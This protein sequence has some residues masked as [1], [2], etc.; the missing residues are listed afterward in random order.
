MKIVIAGAG[1]VGYQIASQLILEKRSVVLIE[2]NELIA[3]EMSNRLDCM[4]ICGSIEDPFVLK[5]AKIE[6]ASYFL[7]LTGSDEINIVSCSIADKFS[8]NIYKVARIR[9]PSYLYLNEKEKSLFNIDYIVNPQSE[10]VDMIL[11]TIEYG[12]VSD[13]FSLGE[14]NLDISSLYID[15]D[16]AAKY[17]NII[18][19]NKAINIPFLVVLLITSKN[20]IL[21]PN[22]QSKIKAGD[23][24][25]VCAN[26][27]DVYKVFEFFNKKTEKIDSI[28]IVGGDVI[29]Q[30]ILDRLDFRKINENIEDLKNKEIEK[31]SFFSNIFSIFKRKDRRIKSFFKKR[32]KIIE[33]D[34]AV[35]KFLSENY[36]DV[37][38]INDSITRDGVFEDNDL[39]KADLI[40]VATKNQE[41]NIVSSLYAKK[42]GIEKAVAIVENKSYEK[43]A[44]ELGI[45]APISFRNS[46][47]SSVLKLIK[48]QNVVNIQSIADGQV[49]IIKVI[50]NFDS[51][52]INR[53][54]KNLNIPKQALI[55]TVASDDVARIPNGDFVL[56]EN[57]IITLLMLKDHKLEVEK[58]FS[59]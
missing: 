43:M 21:I 13:I 1:V 44:K 40:I 59:D 30:G 33:K 8:P 29:C 32:I 55:I 4:V 53:K 23:T 10:V 18:E 35:A 17:S 31:K 38:V 6:D 2:K 26:K 36:R 5:K 7:S 16:I 52:H 20:E 57:D 24:I 37:L 49:E 27:K 12:A 11:K 19:L 48:S 42:I 54:I 15:K 39:T 22:G 41:L 45:D 9:N 34:Y 58:Y 51:K 3:R 50:L 56:Q 25:Y 28:L 47:A 46:I 14:K